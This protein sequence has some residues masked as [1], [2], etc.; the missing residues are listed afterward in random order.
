MIISA[1]RL[2]ALAVI[3]AMS[4]SGFAFMNNNNVAAS[5]AGEGSGPVYGYNV[6][7]ISYS[8]AGASHHGGHGDSVPWPQGDCHNIVMSSLPGHHNDSNVGQICDIT[9]SVIPQS[10]DEPAA[11]NVAAAFN[12]KNGNIIS[13]WVVCTQT[14][15]GS[16]NITTWECN[17]TNS[18]ELQPI[19][20]L[21]VR[22]TS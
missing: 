6:A 12:D 2:G 5:G 15:T 16:N 11:T 10:S 3:A 20:S 21:D 8:V 14:G 1:K 4:T 9:F 17:F 7:H 19:T 18:Q 22:A 13:P